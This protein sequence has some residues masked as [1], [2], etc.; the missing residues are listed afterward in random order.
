[1]THPRRITLVAGLLLV[2]GLPITADAAD[3]MVFPAGFGCPF[4]VQAEPAFLEGGAA[5]ERLR[6]GWGNI[7]LTNLDTGATTVTKSRYTAIDTYD[8]VGNAVVSEI[9]GR[10]MIGF[11]PGDAGP[12]GEVEYPGMLLRVVGNISLTFDLNTQLFTAYSLEGQSTDLCAEL[13]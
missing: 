13:D 9:T 5:S 11:W 4:D 1:M 7:T 2:L 12:S 6:I 8:A 3:P 10:I